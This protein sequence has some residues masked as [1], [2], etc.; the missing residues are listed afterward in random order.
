MTTPYNSHSSVN[1]LHDLIDKF[2]PAKEAALQE[3]YAKAEETRALLKRLGFWPTDKR[4]PVE[5]RGKKPKNGKLAS[6]LGREAYHWAYKNNATY[7]E[8]AERFR[9]DANSIHSYRQYR[10][11]PKLR[12]K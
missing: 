7:T 11:L 5:V 12:S 4:K 10:R 6:E 3:H 9:I 8:A 2:V 1:A